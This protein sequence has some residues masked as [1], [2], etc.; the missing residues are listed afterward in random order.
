M[1]KFILLTHLAAGPLSSFENT[2]GPIHLFLCLTPKPK[3]W[4]GF[5]STSNK[6]WGQTFFYNLFLLN[7]S[8]FLDFYYIEVKRLQQRSVLR[9]E[10]QLQTYAAL[11]GQSLIKPMR[12][13]LLC[14]WA[15]TAPSMSRNKKLALVVGEPYGGS[16][17]LR[18]SQW[19][20]PEITNMSG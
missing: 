10:P 9:S 6:G 11:T 15:P 13:A 14:V 17:D 12:W 16:M 3:Q 20:F 7:F 1:S 8:I 18:D 5:I 2:N 19:K 4:S